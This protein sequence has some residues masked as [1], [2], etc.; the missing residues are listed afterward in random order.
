MAFQI[1]RLLV[2]EADAFCLYRS[3]GTIIICR[4]FCYPPIFVFLSDCHSPPIQVFYVELA[5]H[6]IHKFDLLSCFVTVQV[7]S[8]HH[9]VR[10][11]IT[12]SMKVVY[13]TSG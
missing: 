5:E 13:F 9:A 2:D 10:Q 6:V 1:L 4:M 7:K 11:T 3:K 12:F 8:Y